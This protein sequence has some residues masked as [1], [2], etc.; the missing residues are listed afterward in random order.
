MSL[1][2][3]PARGDNF[4]TGTTARIAG[5]PWPPA[6]RSSRQEGPAPA[7][8]GSEARFRCICSE[9]RPGG[10]LQHSDG[11]G[12]RLG[13]RRRLHP[14]RGRGLRPY[15]AGER[16]RSALPVLERGSAGTTSSPRPRRGSTRR[17]PP[18]TA[19]V[20]VEGYVYPV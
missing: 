14:R 16:Y 6:T 10:Q 7:N 18:A 11:R 17:S 5:A 13:V 3:N 2:W 9:R 4:T 19:L 12:H 20:R 1:W 15:V 8:P